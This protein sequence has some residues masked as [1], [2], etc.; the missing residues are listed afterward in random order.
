[1]GTVQDITERK[2]A[3]AA[4]QKLN[5]EL[6]QRVTQ[7]TEQL[8]AA[9]KELEAFSYSISHDLR[10]PLRA[11]N[12]FLEIIQQE[13]SLRLDAEGLR[14]LNI[15]ASNARRMNELIDDLLAFSRLARQEF[16]HSDVNIRDLVQTILNDPG[17]LDQQ[18]IS[19]GIVLRPLPNVV[20]DASMIRQVFTNLIANAVKFTRN[21]NEPTIEIGATS[22]GGEVIFFVR[23]NGVGFDMKYASKLFKVFQRLH[24][25]EQFEGTGVGL[26]IVHRIVHRHGGRI[27]AEAKVNEGATFYFSLPCQNG[28]MKSRANGEVD[29]KL[30]LKDVEPLSPVPLLP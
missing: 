24:K 5:A 21:V 9:N 22:N 29:H 19:P 4:I 1:V 23:D 7:R 8:E 28:H 20:G 3:E 16:E 25:A 12:G 10:A 30:R 13:H 18:P 15:I 27:W 14:L 26:A 6:E 17:I 11:I 2:Q